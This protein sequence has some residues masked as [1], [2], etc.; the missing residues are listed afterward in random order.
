MSGVA[1]ITGASAGVGRA[2]ADEFARH[3][4][5][6]ALL[7]RDPTRLETA[8]SEV[9]QFGVRALA[10]PTDVADAEAVD[11]AADTVGR[12]LGPIDVWV[13]VA[14]TTVFAPVSALDAVEF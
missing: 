3:G 7:A 9:R 4:F 12:E 14:M 6:V 5:D 2:V 13:N 11:A 8:A 1:V 10:I